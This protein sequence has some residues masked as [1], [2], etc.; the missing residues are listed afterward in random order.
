MQSQRRL[1]IASAL[2]HVAVLALILYVRPI[3]VEPTRFP[4]TAQG[5]RMSLTYS[6]G[7]APKQVPP[8]LTRVKAKS[9]PAPAISASVTLDPTPSQGGSARGSGN[10]TVALATFFPNPRPDL[11]Q[12]PHGTRG[13]VIVDV[14][15]DEQGRIV[16]TQVA[17]SMGDAI[18]QS[19]LATIQTWTFKPAT[20]DG[21]PVPS[22]QELLFH[23]ERG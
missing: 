16:E 18:D 3:H 1:T 8:P 22:E 6:P 12:L 14:V 19:V 13:D 21:V 9:R 20:K 17:H 23:Y 2:L 11:T 5:T 15:I 10:V 7:G 4:G